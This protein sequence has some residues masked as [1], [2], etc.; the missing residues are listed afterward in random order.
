MH[1]SNPE[2]ASKLAKLLADVV[3]AKFIFQ[4][5]HWNVLGPNF[6]EY[7]EF[8][9]TLYVDLEESI[10]PLAE[11]ILKAGFPAPYLLKDYVELS[12]IMEERLDGT[13]PKFMLDSALRVNQQVIACYLDAFQIASS[14]DEQGVIDFL[15][16]R[17]NAHEKWTWQIKSYLGVR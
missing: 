14:C 5:Y 17:I 10:D 2:L 16:A 7:H 11:N 8:F 3:T 12:T 13:S 6:G 15:A 4:G 1:D 9:Q